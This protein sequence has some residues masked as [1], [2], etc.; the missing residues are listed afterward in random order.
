MSTVA[1]I[2]E[3][4]TVQDVVL[5]DSE[6]NF[7]CS[8]IELLR[9]FDGRQRLRFL[10]LHDPTVPIAYPDL[11]YDKLIKEMWVIAYD[12]TRYSGADAM[13]YLSRR[14]PMLF[15]LAPLLHIPFSMPLWRWMYRVI[16]RNRYRIA[17]RKCSNGAC[18]IHGR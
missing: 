12:E 11:T 15:P 18:R 16:A 9:R 2:S 10:S 8:S 13:R 4:Q 6:C 17:G 3:A 7:C 1:I 5:Y 14:L